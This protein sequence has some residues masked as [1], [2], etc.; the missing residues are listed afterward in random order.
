[1]NRWQISIVA[2]L[3][4]AGC[5]VAVG[6]SNG[7]GP[8]NAKAAEQRDIRKAEAIYKD[9]VAAMADDPAKAK[10]LLNE[11]LGFDLYHGAAHNNLGVILLGE[12]KLYDAAEEFEWARKLM[13]GHPQPRVNLAIAL[14]RGGKPLEAIESAK[15]ALEVRPGHMGAI[16]TLAYIQIREGLEDKTTKDHL[17]T[18]ISRSD[19][20]VWRDWANR[21]R[22]RLEAKAL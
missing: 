17:N 18:I 1:M 5:V 3:V 12:N 22:A 19:D 2:S 4:A 10:T 21:Q 8:Y 6:C 9:A 7:R 11:A 13:P 20:Q 15:A 14:E 16:Q